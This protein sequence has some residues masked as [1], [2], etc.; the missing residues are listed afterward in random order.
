MAPI[1][2]EPARSYPSD[3]ASLRLKT[4]Y[5]SINI[6]IDLAEVDDVVI[7]HLSEQIYL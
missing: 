4:L 3:D 5:V 7:H 1:V 2:L 6:Q